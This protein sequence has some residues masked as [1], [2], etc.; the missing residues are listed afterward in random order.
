MKKYILLSLTMSLVADGCGR[1]D[2][3]DAAAVTKQCAIIRDELTKKGKEAGD[4]GMW[5]AHQVDVDGDGMDEIIV[6]IQKGRGLA[7]FWLRYYKDGAWHEV[8]E[9]PFA[10][11][12]SWEICF[13]QD[14]IKNLPR[15]FLKRTTEKSVSAIIFDRKTGAITFEPFDYQE[16]Q[17]LKKS[18]V[19]PYYDDEQDDERE[20]DSR[21]CY[22]RNSGDSSQP[23][24][25]Y[26][27]PGEDTV[28]AVFLDEMGA[29]TAPFDF[30]E[31][32]E[33]RKQGI[34][35]RRR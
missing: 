25:F 17:N 14:D 9:I 33:L 1:K 30:Q 26:H 22:G 21:E 20:P 23:R 16:Y 29:H 12:N 19:I 28:E 31:F 27:K 4:W 10:R 18:G 3:L 5:F 8:S 2:T 6:C 7:E 32:D 35:N 24:L 11:A 15:M 13:R 34:I